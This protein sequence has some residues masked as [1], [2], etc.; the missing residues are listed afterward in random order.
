MPEGFEAIYERHFDSIFRYVLHR[1][2]NVAE[3]E[4]LTSQTFFKALRGI[5]RY[6][7]GANGS[8]EAWLYRIAT[9]EVSSHFR[10]R[11]TRHAA[12]TVPC[13][14]ELLEQR[15]DA[16]NTLTRH[17]LFLA[18]N[19]ALRTLPHIEQ[20]LLALRYFEQRPFGEIA[21]ILGKRPGSLTM[22]THRALGKLRVELEREGID[23]EELR[24]VLDRPVEAGC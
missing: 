19:R 4:D 23:H 6:R 21:E 1:V 13:D 22:R 24:E 8:A 20:A 3:A 2:A 14:D 17:R 16:E 18:V 15:A 11:R 5:D 7:P 9:N 10:R 12:A